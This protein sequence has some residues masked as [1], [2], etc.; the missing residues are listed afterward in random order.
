MISNSN[1]ILNF[2][3]SNKESCSL[4]QQLQIHILFEIF[5]AREG[6]LWIKSIQVVLE[7]FE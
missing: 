6:S 1:S 7:F 4:F 3:N 5:A 2:E